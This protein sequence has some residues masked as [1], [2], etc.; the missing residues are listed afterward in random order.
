MWSRRGRSQ[1]L[2][3]IGC[4]VASDTSLRVE[5]LIPPLGPRASR[6]LFNSNLLESKSIEERAGRPRSQGREDEDGPRGF[7]PWFAWEITC[8]LVEVLR[9]VEAHSWNSGRGALTHS[10]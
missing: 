7:G 3:I 9:G 1:H 8:A 2:E 10:E 4:L 5:C 6:P